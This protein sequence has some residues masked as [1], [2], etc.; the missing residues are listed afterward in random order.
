MLAR[1]SPANG[2]P[3]ARLLQEAKRKLAKAVAGAKSD[4][5]LT[6]VAFNSWL[7]LRQRDGRGAASSFCADHFV[8]EQVPS[9]ALHPR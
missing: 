7:A 2:R 4:H 1:V 3:A 8:S 5:L 9:A 6:V